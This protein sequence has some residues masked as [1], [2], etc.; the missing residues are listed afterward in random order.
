MKSKLFTITLAL[1]ALVLSACGPVR[2]P[3]LENVGPN[4]TAFV[5]PLE[6]DSKGQAKF[7][8]V[9][10]LEERKVQSK[11][12]EVP[13]RERSIGRMWWDYEWIP[14]VRVVKVDRSLVTREW[15]QSNPKGKTPGDLKNAAIAVES[16][17]SIG[18]HVGINITA[19]IQEA[20]ASTYL[21]WHNTK[22]LQEVID[23]NI[24]GFVQ[25][26]LS[27][28]FGSR[29]LEQSK[30]DKNVVFALADKESKEHFQKYGITILNLG[31][32]GGLEFDDQA[33]QDAINN[34]Q[35]SEMKVKVAIQEKLAQ[36]ERNKKDVATAIAARQAAEEFAKAKEA[37]TAKVELEIKMVDAQA[38]LLFAGRV[39]GN[40]PSILPQGTNML[41]GL[42]APAPKK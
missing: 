7:E 26:V 10:Y 20:D 37:Q 16:K 22:S 14:T 27:R 8:S 19:L 3:P 15:S 24:R 35:T 33:I 39:S 25:G 4:E 11:R 29:T 21:Y 5:I 1:S 2:V 28:E 23:T 18:F 12:I 42:D 13:V 41:Y 6:G 31:N 9:K 32:A 30:A 34:T 38:R 17:E 36:D 40:L